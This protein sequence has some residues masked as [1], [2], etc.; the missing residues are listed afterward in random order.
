MSDDDDDDED[1]DGKDND[2]K[3]NNDK[4][5]DDKDDC[6]TDGHKKDNQDND[7][8]NKDDP[9]SSLRISLGNTVIVYSCTIPY[10]AFEPLKHCTNYNL[11]L[12]LH[13]G[14]VKITYHLLRY[15]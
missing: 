14:F 5:N 1:N 13:Q 2:D 9:F 15:T 12:S 10:P 11:F 7:N 6:N 4:D 8:H 3:D